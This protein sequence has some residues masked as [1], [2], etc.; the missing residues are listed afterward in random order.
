VEGPETRWTT[1]NRERMPLRLALLATLL[2]GGC[3]HGLIAPLPD[4]PEGTGATVAIIYYSEWTASTGRVEGGSAPVKVTVD[5]LE[6]LGI[7][8][9][10]Y[11]MLPLPAGERV[12]G[13]I[14]VGCRGAEDTILLRLAVATTSYLR[15]AL[16]RDECPHICHPLRVLY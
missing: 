6:T 15:I 5:G 11:V 3:A 14:G 7:G 4:V 1:D 13:V 2:L 9:G 8:T 12:I 16:A 10:E